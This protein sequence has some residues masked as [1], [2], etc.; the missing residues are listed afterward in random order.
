VRV[1][2]GRFADCAVIDKDRDP[3]IIWTMHGNFEVDLLDNNDDALLELVR[4]F[5]AKNAREVRGVQ[6]ELAKFMKKVGR[7][8]QVS[9][10]IPVH[11]E[12]SHQGWH[13]TVGLEVFG[14]TISLQ[15]WTGTT[16]EK[17][18]VE[19]IGELELFEDA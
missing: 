5:L 13:S 6:K 8:H 9:I 17:T 11:T 16:G 4:A 7:Q 18:T 3:P 2:R 15:R 10:T 19:H 12:V 14:N 1:L